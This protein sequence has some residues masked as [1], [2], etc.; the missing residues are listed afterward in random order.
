MMKKIHDII[1][2][3]K[4]HFMAK[5]ERIYVINLLSW[6]LMSFKIFAIINNAEM[7]MFI[8][9]LFLRIH[10]EVELSHQILGILMKLMIHHT[11]LLSQGVTSVYTN[12][13]NAWD[14]FHLLVHLKALYSDISKK[15]IFANLIFKQWDFIVMISIFY[16]SDACQ[17]GTSSYCFLSKC[18]SAKGERVF[19]HLSI[20]VQVHFLL[21]YLGYLPI[22]DNNPIPCFLK[23]WF[24]NNTFTTF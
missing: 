13:S 23:V 17:V 15:K 9:S 11:G 24:I 8:F 6:H 16:D 10:S 1:C 22:I 20:D 19:S 3:F 7:N 21:I 5:N 18:L 2:T 4:Y 12:I 14:F